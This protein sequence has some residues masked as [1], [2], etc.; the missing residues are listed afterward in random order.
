MGSQNRWFGDPRT[1][2]FTSKPLFFGGSNDSWGALKKERRL[3]L[4]FLAPHLSLSDKKMAL[5]T[6]RVALLGSRL[7]SWRSARFIMKLPKYVKID[8]RTTKLVGGWTNPLEKYARQIGNLPQIGVKIKNIWNHHQEN[9]IN[10]LPGKQVA[11]NFHQLY[12]GNQPRLPKIMVHYVF[13]LLCFTT[14]FLKD[15]AKRLA[16]DPHLGIFLYSE[17]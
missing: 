10:H 2:L 4:P 7:D 6:D 14:Y 12:P 11:V 13:H 8:E 3:P 1:L 16:N 5:G 9:L 15:G 17:K